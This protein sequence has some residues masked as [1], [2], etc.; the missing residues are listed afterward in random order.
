MDS[1]NQMII[2]YKK[3]LPIPLSLHVSMSIYSKFVGFSLVYGA[4]GQLEFEALS[5]YVLFVLSTCI[6]MYMYMY[7]YM[8]VFLRTVLYLD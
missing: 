2:Q 8:Y 5:L 3:N 4:G 7:M 6:Y 1:V